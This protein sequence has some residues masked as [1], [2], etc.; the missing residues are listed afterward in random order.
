MSTDTCLT[1]RSLD[2]KQGRVVVHL[3]RGTTAQ[4]PGRHSPVVALGAE[5]CGCYARSTNS[6]GNVPRLELCRQ[7]DKVIK[8][9]FQHQPLSCAMTHTAHST[10]YRASMHY[11]LPTEL[12]VVADLPAD[13]AE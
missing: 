3:A 2:H 9:E 7:A 8:A 1:L 4:W 11:K 5:G 12:R 13:G 6:G 10:E